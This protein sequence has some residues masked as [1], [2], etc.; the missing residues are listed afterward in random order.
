[1]GIW[2]IELLDS[3]CNG[4]NDINTLPEPSWVAHAAGGVVASL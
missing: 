4:Q 3:A 1:M 2:G